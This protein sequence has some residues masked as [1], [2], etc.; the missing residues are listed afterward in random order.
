[1][2]W[3]RSKGSPAFE[4]TARAPSAQELAART[5]S[6]ALQLAE[7]GN[8]KADTSDYSDDQ[9]ESHQETLISSTR[10]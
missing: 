3:A 1:M 7:S 4:K 6:E 10:A 5:Y 8:E 9:A 2:F